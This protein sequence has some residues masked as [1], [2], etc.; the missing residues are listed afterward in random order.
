MRAPTGYILVK[1]NRYDEKFENSNLY[2]Y[3]QSGRETWDVNYYAE[4][5]AVPD[6]TGDDIVHEVQVGDKVYFHYN[7]FLNNDHNLIISD[8]PDESMFMFRINYFDVLAVVRDGKIIPIGGWCFVEPHV[9]KLKLL[10]AEVEQKSEQQGILKHIG[11][12][13]KGFSMHPMPKVGDMI[14]FGR[15]DAWMNRIEGVE[16]YCMQ[17]DRILAI[18]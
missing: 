17:Q 2:R 18:L 5:V 11:T 1:G 14:A 15:D 10:E 12:P 13:K 16:Y 6:D 7:S 8:N 9:H 3:F 4:V